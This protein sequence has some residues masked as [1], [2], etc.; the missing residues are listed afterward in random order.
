VSQTIWTRCAGTSEV[1]P[2]RGRFHRVVEAQFR[3]STRKLCDSD[4]EQA[5]LEKLIDQRAKAP[6]PAGFEDLHYLLYTPFRHPPLRNG[7]RFGSRAE[8][9]ILYGA[10][11]LPTALAEVAYYR[12]V[13]LAGSAADLGDVATEHT[14]FRF[15]IDA[16]RAVD[17]GAPPFRDYE[18][19]ISSKTRYDASQ[20]L[21][22]QMRADGVQAALYVSAR[23]PS[24]EVNVAVFEN[25]FAP[26][27]PTD[28]RGL[29]CMANRSVVEIRGRELLG[30]DER[31]SFERGQFE[32]GGKLP[33][34]AT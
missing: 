31:W 17:L 33:S 3:N 10:K 26:R 24:R 29:R 7:S 6:V 16:G 21:G 12:F 9:G 11:K 15:G 28:E 8:R 22:A 5:L 20:E 25:V 34:P 2:L 4:E 13:F 1:R 23:A 18:A 30:P 32:I 19:E 14:A 27:T